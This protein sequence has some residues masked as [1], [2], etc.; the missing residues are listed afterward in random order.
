MSLLARTFFE[1]IVSVM[2]LR[3]VLTSTLIYFLLF[4]WLSS[5]S[6]HKRA[7]ATSKPF[8]KATNKQC[9]DFLSNYYRLWRFHRN[10]ICSY[11]PNIWTLLIFYSLRNNHMH[12][13]V[14]ILNIYNNIKRLWSNTVY[15]YV[16]LPNDMMKFD[17]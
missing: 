16:I 2:R 13:C 4:W 9:F 14:F 5:H 8:R 1:R 3:D 7:H 11:E 17:R 6:S 12:R 15:M 10:S